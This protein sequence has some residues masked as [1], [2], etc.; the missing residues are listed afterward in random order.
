MRTVRR[1]ASV[2]T[3]STGGSA[4]PAWNIAWA[5]QRMPLPLISAVEPSAL[6]SSMVTCAPAV[7][8]V[9]RSNP[10]APSPVRR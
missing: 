1:P 5:R 9:A 6:S 4:S 8:L 10:S 7:P 2:A 3:V